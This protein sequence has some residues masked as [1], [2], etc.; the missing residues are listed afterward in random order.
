MF[1]VE[2]CGR[3]GIDGKKLLF[4]EDVNQISLV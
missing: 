4:I 1:H 2:H 3:Y